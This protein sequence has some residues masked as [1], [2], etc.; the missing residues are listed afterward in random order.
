MAKRPA[1]KK[2]KPPHPGEHPPQPPKHQHRHHTHEELVE[3]VIALE[4]QIMALSTAVS[5]KFDEQDKKLTDLSDKVDAFIAAGGSTA[6]DAE[7]VARLT[8]QGQTVDAIAAKLTP[9]P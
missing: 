6:N 9:A 1:P 4:T 5:A 3:L 7:V 8:K 2:P